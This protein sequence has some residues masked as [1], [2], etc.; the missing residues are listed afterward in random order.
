MAHIIYCEE[1][2]TFL[3]ENKGMLFWSGI[4]PSGLD[5]APVF[6]S[7]AEACAFIQSWPM[8]TR[9]V[10]MRAQV[11][12]VEVV[13]DIIQ[14]DGRRFASSG[15]CAMAGASGWLSELPLDYYEPVYGVRP[16]VH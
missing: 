6:D 8:A 16:S 14:E 12:F 9:I 7:V 3:G 2:G 10:V 13:P 11:R 1:Y 15:A 5:A 4:H